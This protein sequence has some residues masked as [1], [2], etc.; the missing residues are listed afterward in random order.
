MKRVLAA[1]VCLVCASACSTTSTEALT[2]IMVVVRSDL[3]DLDSVEIRVD[4]MGEPKTAK[5][6]LAKDKLPRT[7]AVV[8][9]GGPL[10]PITITAR[11]LTDGDERVTRSAR[12]SFARGKNVALVLELAS[13]CE[14][15]SC[16]M[17]NTTCIAGTCDSNAVDVDDLPKWPG[18]VGKLDTGTGDAGVSEG[19]VPMDAGLDAEVIIDA[20]VDG[21]DGTDA[22]LGCEADKADCDDDGTCETK[23]GTLKHCGACG[24][25]CA[26]G[27]KVTQPHAKLICDEGLCAVSCD[28][29]FLDLDGDHDNGCEVPGFVTPPAHVDANAKAVLERV[30]P[31]VKVDCDA[32][33]DF[34]D[35]AAPDEVD[36]CGDTVRPLVVV[37]AGGPELL[38][39]PVRGLDVRAGQTLTVRGV[40]PVV[41]LVFGD[42]TITG[43][44]SVGASGVTPGAGGN[45]SCATGTGVSGGSGGG[46]GGFGSPGGPGGDSHSGTAGGAAG[47]AE[48][49][50]DLA[51]LRGGCAGGTG[52]P[53]TPGGAGGGGGGALQVSVVG[54]LTVSGVVT[55]SGGG[56]GT[57]AAAGQTGGGGGGSGGAILLEAGA[58][59]LEATGWVTANGGSGGEASSQDNL[60]HVG[61]D[62]AQ[63]G[64][65]AAVGGTGT[66][67]AGD[68]GDGAVAGVAA[69]G[70]K[71][72][73]AT[74]VVLTSNRG[75]GGG[76]GGGVGRV[77]FKS[78]S[79]SVLG[80]TSPPAELSTCVP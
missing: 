11:G 66:G 67:N 18:S 75:G 38:V 43:T 63:A 51:L 2:Q 50:A 80:M 21:A 15:V 19:G 32:T 5:A 17:K 3:T 25:A 79:C 10:G 46:G 1:L 77:A 14:D 22:A 60:G 24:D 4:G 72:G 9:R 36:V 30:A 31:A 64:A 74:V 45:V 42:A 39:I 73:G 56:G 6:S 26:F 55:A 41:F 35:D 49:S 48:G 54:A 23:L 68:G 71:D 16:A 65:A 70:G 40:R 29:G 37:Q 20:Q 8:Y 58:L 78:E 13:E 59:L 33:L 44:L 52:S 57:P 61:I 47:L 7:L 53:G 69:A 12:L 28:A 62:G 76:G 34:G 27:S